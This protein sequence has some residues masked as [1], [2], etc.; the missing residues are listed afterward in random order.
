MVTLNI[1]MEVDLLGICPHSIVKRSVGIQ[2]P[3]IKVDWWLMESQSNFEVSRHDSKS[4]VVNSP[5]WNCPI[6]NS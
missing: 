5:F 4:H 2:S 6:E 1:D 3:G